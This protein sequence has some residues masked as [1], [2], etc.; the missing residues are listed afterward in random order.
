MA[1]RWIQPLSDG[2]I[3][4]NLKSLKKKFPS[5]TGQLNYLLG[6]IDVGS[7]D[8]EEATQFAKS[9]GSNISYFQVFCGKAYFTYNSNVGDKPTHLVMLIDQIR[10]EVANDPNQL[11]FAIEFTKLFAPSSQSSPDLSPEDSI[12]TKFLRIESALGG[13][14]ERF[15][16]LQTSFAKKNQELRDQHEQSVRELKQQ[17]EDE[18]TALENEIKQKHAE[19]EKVRSELDDRSNTHARRAIRSE[20]KA[21]I[22]SSLGQSVFAPQTL[23]SK[24]FI[25]LSYISAIVVLC[26]LV[27]WST[28]IFSTAIVGTSVASIWLSGAKATISTVSA[29]GLTLLF[30]KW[31]VSWLNQQ[32]SFE[33][34]LSS[35]KVDIDRASW[36]AETLLEWNQ[37]SPGREI[38]NE[39]LLSFTR[40][41]FDWDAKTEDSH[42]ASDSLASAILGSAAKLEIGPNGAKIDMD[43]KSLK[44]LEKQ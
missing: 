11:N 12:A 20:L 39:L 18:K 32:A 37:E 5:L 34:V 25:R 23:A 10:N 15:E 3:I 8:G 33:R 9:V 27:V 1:T 43:R 44:N 29:I 19:L 42:S 24:F 36:V 38:P 2:D 17:I 30:L 7:L 41:L 21:S 14:V 6:T 4:R 22:T 16:D 26:G 31:E 35:T 28:F 13:A 40:R